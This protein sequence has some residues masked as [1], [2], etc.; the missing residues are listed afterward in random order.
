MHAGHHGRYLIGKPISL[1]VL[2]YGLFKVHAD[3]RIIGI[4]GFLLRTDQNEAVLIDTGFPKHYAIDAQ[5]ASAA[6]DLGKF[7]EVLRLTQE[8]LP[9]GQLGL[10]GLTISDI[11]LLILTHSHIDHIGGLDDLPGVPVLL[12]RAELDLPRPLYFGG[13]RP[14]EWPDRAY[15]TIDADTLIGPGFQALPSPGHAPG[16]LAFCVDL[17]HTGWVLLTSD[18]ISRPAEV[19]EKFD[20]APNPAQACTS[21][22]RLLAIAGQRNALIIY[23]HCPAQWPRLKKAPYVYD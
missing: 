16:Q 21:A 11:D 18:A 17:P 4:C 15:L 23:G 7:G 13:H 22:A 5:A 1:M 19:D 8:N 6:D 2:D 14:M 12:A 20:T 10:A 9:A 3:G